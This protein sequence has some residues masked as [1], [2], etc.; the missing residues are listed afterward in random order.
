MNLFS[1]IFNCK[2]EKISKA[3]ESYIVAKEAL[4]DVLHEEGLELKAVNKRTA[5]DTDSQT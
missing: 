1:I 3:Y 4:I 5:S 2:N